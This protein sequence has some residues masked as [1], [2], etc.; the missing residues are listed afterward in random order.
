LN[1][2]A[3]RPPRE[4]FGDWNRNLESYASLQSGAALIPGPE[5]SLRRSHPESN[6]FSARKDQVMIRNRFRERKTLIANVNGL[7]DTSLSFPCS[8]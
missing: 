2:F 7:N 1:E 8:K 5:V 4:V 6:N 3:A